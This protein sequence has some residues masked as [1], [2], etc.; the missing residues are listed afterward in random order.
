M[1]HERLVKNRCRHQEQPGTP[2]MGP[3]ACTTRRP[4]NHT[5]IHRQH[6]K[7][8][9]MSTSGSRPQ[10]HSHTHT[11]ASNNALTQPRQGQR[12][13]THTHTHTHKHT[14]VPSPSIWPWHRLNCRCQSAR[15]DYTKWSCLAASV[16][17][18]FRAFPC[19]STP[20]VVGLTGKTQKEHT[21][22]H[23]HTQTDTHTHTHTDTQTH[24]KQLMK[25][26][27]TAVVHMDGHLPAPTMHA[28]MM[29]ADT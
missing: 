3:S 5:H 18:S 20:V 4:D 7:P 11:H 12:T 21:H 27:T 19:S 10:T 26:R 24:T 15:A 22:T 2:Q 23:T 13:E 14:P 6:T 28:K 9:A 16:Q 17:G 29:G 1:A 25:Q 8:N